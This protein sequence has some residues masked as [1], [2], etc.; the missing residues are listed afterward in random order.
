MVSE[1]SKAA[2]SGLAMVDRKRA[3]ESYWAISNAD[4]AG[5]HF[6]AELIERPI[7]S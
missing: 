5:G 4:E 1:K 3:I 6:I 2:R 7:S